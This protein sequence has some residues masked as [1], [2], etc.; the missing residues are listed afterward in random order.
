MS[1]KYP[2]AVVFDLDYTLW[3]CWC[4]THITMP[5]KPISKKEVVDRYGMLLKLYKDVENIL[6]ELKS[7]DVTIIGASRTATPR[8]AQELLSLFHIN[9]IP[10]IKYF[11]SL[12]W[13]Q[14]SKIKHI[15]KAAKH[16]KMHEDLERGGFILFDDE[17]RNRDVTS[18]NCEFVHIDETKG[19]TR[20]VFEKGLQLWTENKNK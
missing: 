11:H 5:L 7:Q 10:M 19:L 2:S 15:T 17:L 6:M 1:Y 13:G 16:L 14:G 18:I 3:P 12:Q 9:D 4:D 8:V 20:A